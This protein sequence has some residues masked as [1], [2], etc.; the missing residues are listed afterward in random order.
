M[1]PKRIMPAGSLYGRWTLIG[2]APERAGYWLCKCECGTVTAVDGGNLR[3]GVS[4][5]CGCRK[6]ERTGD[7]HRT[8]GQSTGTPEYTAWRSAKRRCTNPNDR[9]YADYGG[10]GITVC[11]EWADFARFYADMGLRP[12][13]QHSLDR[14]DND[15]PYAPWNCRWATPTEQMR[16]RRTTRLLTHQGR[17]QAVGTWADELGVSPKDIA[18]RL[19]R[20]WSTERALSEP[21]RRSTKP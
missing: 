16:N 20:G 8:H 3:W 2:P 7:T 6:R 4:L 5:S 19:R 12:S 21:F 14:V 1:P 11:P 10:R 9:S 17:T 15:G 18:N 13:P